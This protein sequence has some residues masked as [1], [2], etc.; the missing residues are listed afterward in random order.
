MNRRVTLGLRTSW[1]VAMAVMG[2]LAA[3][4][5]AGAQSVPSGWSARDIGNVGVTGSSSGS[6]G[7]F[8]LRAAGADIWG[9]ADGFQYAYRTLTGDGEIITRVQSLSYIQAW[10]KAGVMMRE[11]LDPGAKHAFMLVSPGKGNAFQRRP[12]S[13]GDSTSS[14]TSGGPG[15]F[16][17]VTRTGN[18]FD[19]YQSTDGAN[20]SWVASEWIDMPSTI[21]V[22]V[23]V[24]SHLYGVLTTATFSDT[25]VNQWSGA[26]ASSSSLPSGW[27]NGDVGSVGAG[28]W[29]ASSGNDFAMA[30]AGADVWDYQDAFHYAYRTLSGDGSIVARVYSLDWADAWSKSGVMMRESLSPSSAHA[31]MLV[32]AGN[33]VAFQRR[34]ATGGGSLHTAGPSG[35]APYYVKLVRSG[36]TFSGYASYDGA[37]WTLVGSEYISM[38]STIYVG[39][40][41]TSHHYGALANTYLSG[42]E[43]VQGAQAAPVAPQ[44]PAQSGSSGGTSLRVMQWNVHHGGVGTDGVYNPDRVAAW[45][46]YVNPDVVSLNEV[47]NQDQLNNI[48]WSLNARTGVSWS[49]TF[50]PT[51]SLITRLPVM[52]QNYCAYAL[53][54]SSYTNQVAPEFTVNVGGRWLAMWSAHLNADSAGSR[55]AE[56]GLLQ[57]CLWWLPGIVSGDFNMQS[58][59][60]EYWAMIAG[61]FTDAWDA[62]R[63]LGTNYNYDGNCDGCTR[64]SRI[65]YQFST[66]SAWF[67][68]VRSG[69][70]IDTRDA[71][72][73]MPSDHKPFVI[74]YNV[75]P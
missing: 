27:A 72:G 7:S 65:D 49:A 42:L 12:Y 2:A 1:L 17:R 69:Q 3:P 74:T 15:Y 51:N 56:V 33:G 5:V 18:N 66:S 30:G 52:N 73:Y 58:S 9:T 23:A 50:S 29:T 48:V 55:V 68:T 37:N 38:A 4:A 71:Y 62:A 43:V 32:S 24:S 46:A 60:G 25:V 70:M 54:S 13:N 35:A 14:A 20:W 67:L 36:N 19:A 26:S 57:T 28:G 6:G 40:A 10:S 16:V 22:G 64:N 41:V 75:A 31:F 59:S 34:P 21:Y 44:A 39:V 63:N 45:I 47:D 53:Y 61:G 11:S 8:T